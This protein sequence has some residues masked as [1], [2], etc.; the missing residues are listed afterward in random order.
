MGKT[1]WSNNY[2]P[3]YAVHAEGHRIGFVTC[4]QCGA[5]VMLSGDADAMTL[6]R[7][8]HDI[9]AEAGHED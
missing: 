4:L 1:E 5:V 6:H 8:W 3:G 9:D 7:E 2:G